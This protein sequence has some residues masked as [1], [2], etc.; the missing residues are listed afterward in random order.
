M[1]VKG[2]KRGKIIEILAELNVPDG[3]E[4]IIDIPE[5]HLIN[6]ETKHKKLD[7]VFDAWK[8]N[9]EIAEIFAE[10]DKERHADLGR[11]IEYFDD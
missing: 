3:Q 6:G 5:I 8:D 11:N 1:K 7:E 4:I 2:I 9:T 10:I